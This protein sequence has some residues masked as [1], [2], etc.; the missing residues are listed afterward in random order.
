SKDLERLKKLGITHIVNLSSYDNEF[1]TTFTYHRIEV[2][3]LPDQEIFSRL[4]DAVKFVEEGLKGGKVL[5]HCNAGQSR[6]GSIVTAFLVKSRNLSVDDALK[7]ARS[8]RKQNKV[9]PNSGFM[10]Q[11]REYEKK[12]KNST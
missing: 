12:L 9:L 4:E 3:D 6:A 2:E 11:L 1:P 5:V 10:K 8:K 7:F